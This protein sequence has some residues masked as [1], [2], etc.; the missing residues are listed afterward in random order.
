MENG[1]P[2]VSVIMSM[3]NDEKHI[4]KSLISL[5]N[6]AYPKNLFEIIIVDSASTDNSVFVVE[7]YI[8]KHKNIFLYKLPKKESITVALN[9]GIK[10]SAGSII[11]RLDCHVDSP[12]NYIAE[13]V[14]ALLDGKADLVSGVIVPMGDN[15]V[16]KSVSLA[17]SSHIGIGDARLYKFKEPV[18]AEKGYLGV[19]TKEMINSLGG[20][21]ENLD[22]ADDFDLFYRIIKKGGKILIL[23]GIRMVYYCRDSFLSLFKQYFKYGYTKV[24]VFKKYR[25]ILSIKSIIPFIASII[26]ISLIISGLFVGIL[27]Y[28]GLLLLI[29]YILL[30]F[31]TGIIRS[32]KFDKKLVFHTFFSFLLLHLSHSLG[33]LYGIFFKW[34]KIKK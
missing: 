24:V 26:F 19:Y 34:Y 13:S 14:T 11:V 33:F 16:S 6:Q 32:V 27:S 5:L 3:Y 29:I 1:L 18:Y 20:Y 8:K 22:G 25:K 17:L 23:P 31:I 30:V 15:N 12:A 28:I 7:K 9:K 10:E 4:E 21:D 2:L